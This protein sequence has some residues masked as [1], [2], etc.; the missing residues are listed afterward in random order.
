MIGLTAVI[1]LTSMWHSQACQVPVGG[2]AVSALVY[3]YGTEGAAAAQFLNILALN[4][5][6]RD[7][8]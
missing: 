4:S 8:M 3:V 7:V 6:Q 1:L 5:N 2:R